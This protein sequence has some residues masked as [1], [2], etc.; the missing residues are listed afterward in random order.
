MLNG[1]P[2]SPQT[3]M[4]P[5]TPMTPATPTTPTTSGP[6]RPMSTAGPMPTGIAAGVGFAGAIIATTLAVVLHTTHDPVLALIP[7]GLVTAA[8]A[9]LTSWTG[10]MAAA[11]ICWLLDSGFVIGREAQLTFSS[12]AQMAALALVAIAVIAGTAGRA[13]R[14]LRPQRSA[15][16]ILVQSIQSWKERPETFS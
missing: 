12:P 15:P 10:G 4:I 1:D 9:G 8:I 14:A 7:L 3:P 2:T 11:W 5:T 13:H 6:P 16:T